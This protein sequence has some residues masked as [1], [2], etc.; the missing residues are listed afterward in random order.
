MGTAQFETDLSHYG[1]KIGIQRRVK[2]LQ[3]K[4]KQHPSR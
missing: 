4:A 3:L 2:F 1:N